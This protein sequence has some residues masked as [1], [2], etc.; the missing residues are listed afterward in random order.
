M[1]S[2]HRVHNTL[3]AA[4][5]L[6]PTLLFGAAAWLNR[7]EVLREGWTNARHM[8]IIMDEHAHKV[9]DTI[10]LA[11]DRID[12]RRKLIPQEPLP[13]TAFNAFLAE[14]RGSLE[15]ASSIWVS[16]ADGAIVGSRPSRWCNFLSGLRS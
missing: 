11:L 6:V 1:A 9:F 2:P 10:D 13:S 14:L 4:A 16:N 5:V 7:H 12:D 8:S 15:H 3:I